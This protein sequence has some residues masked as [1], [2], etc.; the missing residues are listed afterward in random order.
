MKPQEIAESLEYQAA[1]TISMPDKDRAA[2]EQA[3][4]YMR[5]IAKRRA[6]MNNETKET[7][8][9]EHIIKT[10]YPK[11]FIEAIRI[12]RIR[13]LQAKLCKLVTKETGHNVV[14]ILKYGAIERK[15]DDNAKQN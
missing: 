3:A 15:E 7:K 12:T 11:L 9:F 4:T 6:T 1:H 10:S 5:K 2:L 13:H 8:F 14:A